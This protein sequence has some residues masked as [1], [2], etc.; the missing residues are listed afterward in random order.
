M[1]DRMF[2][3]NAWGCAIVAASFWLSVIVVFS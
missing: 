3:I 2:I 1:T